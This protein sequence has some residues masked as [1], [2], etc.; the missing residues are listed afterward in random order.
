MFI[1][2]ALFRRL[3]FIAVA[4]S[5]LGLATLMLG[6]LILAPQLPAVES[7]RDIQLQTPLRVFS[8]EGKLMAVYGEKRRIP[9]HYDEIPSLMSGAFLAAEDDRFYQHP[10]VDYQGLMRAVYK[11]LLTGQKV[12]GG[13]T[14]TMQLA[15]NFFLSNERTY[16]RKIKEI[17]LAL[18]IEK[19]LS[20]HEILA[21]YLNKIYLGHRAY[22]IGAAADAYYGLHVED[23]N[24]AQIAMIAGLPKAPS[25]FNPI[26]NPSRALIRRNYVLGRMLKLD[27]ISQSEYDTAKAQAV[28]AK[29]HRPT[30]ELD[31]NYISEMVRA[32]MYERYGEEAYTSGYRVF[33]TIEAERQQAA[34][35]A[36]QKGI[37]AYDARHGYRGAEQHI[38]G[39]EM[40]DQD[41]LVKRLKKIGDIRKKQAGIVLEVSVERALVLLRNGKIE[42]NLDAVKHAK[43]YINENRKGPTP[44]A[45]DEVL[46]VGDL[47]RVETES[48][49][50]R[51]TQA[52]KVSS[53][54]VSLRPQDGALLAL[55][56]GYDFYHNKFN[57]ATQAQRQ[58]GSSFKP[59]IYSAA[60]SAGFTPASMINDAPVVFEDKKLESVWR[61]QNYSGKFFGPTRLRTAI[62]K[63]R[64]MVSIRLLR[65]IGQKLA[66]QHAS[67]FGFNADALPK[68][69]TLAL[70]SGAVTPMQLAE[71]YTVFANGGYHV[72]P[73]FIERIESA[74]GKVIYRPNIQR[75]CDLKCQR[76]ASELAAHERELE[77]LGIEFTQVS[78]NNAPR[79]VDEAN[80][81][82]INSMLRDV[83][84]RGTGRK[85][86]V[87]GRKDI[88]GKTG[89]TNEQRDAWFAGFHPQVVTTVWV[90]FD[91]HKPLG[92]SEFG[93]ATALPI[94]I[95]YMR[96][97]L[98]DVAEVKAVLPADMIQL[99]INPETG[100]LVSP[101]DP[102]GVPE[103]FHIDHVPAFDQSFQAE[104]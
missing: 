62:I 17:L 91:E 83:V 86:R 16:T 104:P 77:E 24:L 3:V 19:A 82:Q 36:V 99:N 68:D 33:T 98:R 22:G 15:R 12:Q 69:L 89:T 53:A 48:D 39:A 50:W 81:Y 57:R 7:L 27:M 23:L 74:E 46:A 102:K 18:R 52:P 9:L 13:S 38:D 96:T 58:P 92:R 11:L 32:E 54:L 51:L 45:V 35:L 6:Y 47:I 65:I 85:A 25:R 103:V 30:I 1:S 95:D 87:L 4:L 55:S 80:I 64:N 75:V 60:L 94:W 37:E 40:Q 59:F 20:K 42:L 34:Q 2:K 67:K 100:L 88:A 70:G 31:A 78:N 79:V 10:G 93:G 84:Q 76:L 72:K 71:G 28:V 90:G 66:R 56:G 97:A 21:L 8:K 41:A 101:D 73:Y 14:I 5:A 44:K 61:P 63:S 43:P 29:R 26:S 49:G